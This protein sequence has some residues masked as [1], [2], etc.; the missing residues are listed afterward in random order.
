MN[1][2]FIKDSST[3]NPRSLNEKYIDNSD[4]I[5]KLLEIRI[6]IHD[7]KFKMKKEELKNYYFYIDILEIN[8]D[9]IIEVVNFLDFY[10]VNK[11]FKYKL[12]IDLNFKK[13]HNEIK[14]NIKEINS[15]KKYQEFIKPI[16][17]N[18]NFYEKLKEI[19]KSTLIKTYLESKRKMSNKKYGVKFV[20]EEDKCDNNLKDGYKIFMNHFEKIFILLKI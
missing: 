14:S 20:K 16:L 2:F 15:P 18:E 1:N 5:D 17:E 4:Y 3:R 6:A 12:N 10:I 11:K 19:I 8:L 7:E 9:D 13:Y